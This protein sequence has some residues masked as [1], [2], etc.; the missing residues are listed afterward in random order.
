MHFVGKDR[1]ITF[2][3]SFLVTGLTTRIHGNTKSLAKHALTLD[4]VEKL[5]TFLSVY[6]V[7][8]EIL[9][10][11]L[12][13]I[14]SYCHPTQQRRYSSELTLSQ[15]PSKADINTYIDALSQ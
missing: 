12:V 2:K 7:S 11:F 3:A 14:S 4:E 15:T 10:G 6:I 1:F 8:G 13:T 9:L 5:V